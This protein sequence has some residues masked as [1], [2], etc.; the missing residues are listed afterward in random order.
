MKGLTLTAKILSWAFLPLFTPVYALAIGLYIENWEMD[1]FQRDC[2]YAIFNPEAKEVLLYLF[3]AFSFLAPALT[4][5]FMNLR[6]KVD[7]IMLEKRSQRLIPSL[8][9]ILYG[10]M[11]MV[12]LYLK[13][14]MGINGG[15]FIYGLALG[16]LLTVILCTVLTFNWKV[17][18]HA[19]GMGILSGFLVIYFYYMSYFPLGWL[20]LVLLCSGI[21]MSARMYLKL[22]NLG[23]ILIGYLTGFLTVIAACL[24]YL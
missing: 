11:L 14:P 24:F 22:H 20:L 18:L 5:V 23:Q 10:I 16:S 12:I 19:A 7:S 15:K 4:V 2:L 8:L 17:S 13:V 1:Y 21:V 9:T 6:G 3:F